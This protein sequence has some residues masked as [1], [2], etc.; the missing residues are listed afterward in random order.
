MATRWGLCDFGYDPDTQA[1]IGTAWAQHVRSYGVDLVRLTVT[2]GINGNM[3]T[4]LF[5]TALEAYHAAGVTAYAEFSPAFLPTVTASGMHSNMPLN[6]TGDTFTSPWIDGVTLRGE[7]VARQAIQSGLTMTIWGNESNERALI[8]PGIVVPPGPKGGAKAPAVAAAEY[9]QAASRLRS[10]GVTSCYNGAL[11][12]LPQTGTDIRNPYYAAW[13]TAFYEACAAHGKHAPYPWAGWAVNCE[14]AWTTAALVKALGVLRGIMTHYGDTGHIIIT[15]MG[16]QNGHG[17]DTAAAD[18]TF[19]AMDA[20]E[21]L[22]AMV[23]QGPGSV[24]YLGDTAL[25]TDYGCYQWRQ[26]GGTLIPLGDYPWGGYVR[27]RWA[28]PTPR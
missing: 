10:V 16:W 2:T 11:S 19:S 13:L 7:G 24:P 22:C 14:G 1:V 15:E 3:P 26:N 27:K 6:T 23:F 9:W 21:A 5:R 12:V 18:A 8:A 4:G 28:T 17:I 20:S 25:Y